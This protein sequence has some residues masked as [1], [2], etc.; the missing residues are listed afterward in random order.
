MCMRHDTFDSVRAATIAVAVTAV[1]PTD[2]VVQR[3]FFVYGLVRRF[4]A[5]T[6]I[7][8]YMNMFIS[9]H[10][11]YRAANRISSDGS[12]FVVFVVVSLGIFD[13]LLLFSHCIF[14]IY[15]IQLNSSLDV[16]LIMIFPP[17]KPPSIHFA[18]RV[19]CTN[20]IFVIKTGK[21]TTMIVRTP[22]RKMCI[23]PKSNE[24]K[25]K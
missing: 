3:Q 2:G 16:C 17:T 15:S 13:R 24:K 19:V 25:L 11:Y 21:K 22:Q 1:C 9:N 23:L 18:H 5:L 20:T 8:F 10:K 14:L 7:H 4:S 12:C 6:T